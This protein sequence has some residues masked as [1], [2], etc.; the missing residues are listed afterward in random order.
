MSDSQTSIPP[1]AVEQVLASIQA[2]FPGWESC[3]DPRSQKHEVKYNGS[4][5]DLALGRVRPGRSHIH[6][7]YAGGIRPDPEGASY[8][9]PPLP[10][11]SR[12]GSSRCRRTRRP[13]GLSQGHRILKGTTRRP[14]FMDQE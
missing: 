7:G 2:V 4:A 8:D 9:A 12:D 6:G 5:V 13:S 11:P 14:S 3:N 10:G 1:S